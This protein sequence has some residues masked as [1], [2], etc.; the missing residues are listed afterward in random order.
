MPGLAH[1]W[2]I[3]F[4]P[5]VHARLPGRR[6]DR[7]REEAKLKF[8]A[9]KTS[10][11]RGHIMRI[12]QHFVLWH[13]GI[14]KAWTSRTPA[15][16]NCL[17]RYAAGKKRLVE[18]GC[19]YGVNTRRLRGVMAP[20]GVLFG[21]DPYPPGRLGFSAIQYIAMREVAKVPN[22]HMRWIRET[23]AQAARVLRAAGEKPVD[24]LFIDAVNSYDGLRTTWEA[25]RPLVAPGGV[26]VLGDSRASAS[27]PIDN[28]GSAVYAR[29]VVRQDP[30]FA[31]VEA[32]DTLTVFRRGGV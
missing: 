26:V 24:F 17:E 3:R 2:P 31:V 21:V 15:E 10:R 16:C 25:W 27:R 9:G 28:L 18:I 5:A 29:E 19:W 30:D 4:A 23:D 22:G 1:L 7:F 11:D 20:D 32:V 13:L 8:R 6:G 14:T 12:M